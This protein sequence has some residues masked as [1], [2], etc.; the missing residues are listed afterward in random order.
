MK[1]TEARVLLTGAAGGIGAASAHALLAAGACV[2]LTG[3]DSARLEQLAQS[4][5]QAHAA[6]AR[7]EWFAGDLLTDTGVADLATRAARWQCNVLLH[8]AGV[9]LF[10]Q[11]EHASADAIEQVLATNLLAPM[12]LTRALLPHL[13]A[14]ASA[15][16]VCVGSVLGGLGLPGYAVYSASKFGLRGFAEAL[17]RE[18]GKGPLR[19]QYLGPRSTKTALNSASAEA[20]NRATGTASDPP[21]TVASALVDLLR[22]G[23]PERFLG[24]PER[25]AVR[26]NGCAPALL[27]GAFSSHREHLLHPQ[28]QAAAE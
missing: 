2:L 12:L 22:S 21:E 3:R 7:V 13:R 18:L 8:N 15:R 16:V 26:M 23:Q 5:Q 11:F 14:Q 20:F 4:L 28:V 19:V 10:G 25:F 24:V 9:G 1:L 17:R 27:D 6:P